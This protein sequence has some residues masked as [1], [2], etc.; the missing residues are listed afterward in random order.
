MA[1]KTKT[2]YNLLR[3]LTWV[4][5][6]GLCV[7]TGAFI[8]NYVF[9]LLKPIA[10]HNL[11][12]GLN[13]SALYETS[14]MVY[15]KLFL[16]LIATSA[17]KAY[18]FYGVVSLF[19]KLD[20]VRPFS[21]EIV[22]RIVRIGYVALSVGILH[23]LALQYALHLESDGNDLGF[24]TEYWNDY[25]GFL[26]MSLIVFVIVQVFKKGIELQIENDLTL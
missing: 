20:F 3:V 7:Q 1:I 14:K 17:L 19:R 25:A 16:L 10:T 26:M 15:S 22:L 23:L 11:Y 9:S 18:L 4:I 5:F 21:T 12:M 2:L 8:F 6:I 24:I 13:L